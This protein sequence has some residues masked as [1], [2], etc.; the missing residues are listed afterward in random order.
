MWEL[1][2][3][4]S[5]IIFFLDKFGSLYLWFCKPFVTITL[6]WTHATGRTKEGVNKIVSRTEPNCSIVVA[7]KVSSWLLRHNVLKV[8]NYVNHWVLLWVNFHEYDVL[9]HLI[10]MDLSMK[11]VGKF[12]PPIKFH[13]ASSHCLVDK[14]DKLSRGHFIGE[15]LWASDVTDVGYP[16]S[17]V[18]PSITGSS[19]FRASIHFF[20]YR[21]SRVLMSMDLPQLK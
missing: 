14:W 15:A 9:Y 6:Q 18:S 17:P 11:Y 20:E 8:S 10:F 2:P 1:F 5:E 12:H 21:T 4:K 7:R 16:L 13:F 3:V 19:N